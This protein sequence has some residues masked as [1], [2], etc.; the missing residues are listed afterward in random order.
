MS[1]NKSYAVFGL[2]RYGTAVAKE[3]V[4][5][6]AEVLAVDRN[7]NTVN[8]IASDIPVCKC[9]DVTDPEV[10]KRLDIAN[11][12][13]V[14]VAMAENFE[15]SVMT[16]MLCKEAGV[17]TV[18]VKCGDEMHSRILKRVG[19][20]KIIF[21]ENE[22]GMRLAKNLLTSGFVDMIELSSDVSMVEFDVKSEW[23]GKSLI[24]LNL[25]RKYSLNVVALCQNGKV[26]V[27]IDPSQ[28]LETD[29][30]LIVI[31]DTAKLSKL[32]D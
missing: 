5:N 22:S 10:I 13:V 7:V 11:I 29:M 9:A 2:G 27:N 14:I 12:D 24:D 19:A 18:I 3:L 4:K 23:I 25:R 16:T 15:A 32:K 31:A 30:K 28:P 20:D 8:A 26:I 1:I 17:R 6:G 21:P